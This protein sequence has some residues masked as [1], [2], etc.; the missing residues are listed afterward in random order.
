MKNEYKLTGS[1]LEELEHYKRQFDIVSD[2]LKE[3]CNEEK[4]D[5]TYGFE[6]GYLHKHLRDCFFGMEEILKRVKNK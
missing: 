1:D 5:I 3:L 6:L 2:N 4:S